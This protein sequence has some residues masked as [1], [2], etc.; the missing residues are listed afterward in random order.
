MK[1]SAVSVLIALMAL[2]A[3]V[4]GPA[5]SASS[6]EYEVTSTELQIPSRDTEIPATVVA[7]VAEADAT[8]PLVVLHHGHGGGRNENGGLARVAD[9]LAKAGIISIRF[10]FAGAGDSQEPFTE[11]SY[12]TMLADS[13]AALGYALANLPV[14]EERIGAFGYSEG[15]AVVAM[16]A[17]ESDTPYKAVALMGPVA[18]PMEVFADSWGSD[19]AFTAYYEEAQANGFAGVTTPWGQV[20]A[21]SLLWFDETL[22]ADPA[23]DIASFV[24]PVLIVWG[25]AEQ[26]IP[27]GEVEAY[28]ATT[29]GSATSTKVVTI[30]EADH[31]YGFYSDQ[32]EVDEL[33]HSSL[34]DFFT[35]ALAGEAGAG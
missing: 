12:T 10:D 15:S 26:V 34:V 24:G 6:E 27:Y 20:Q 32:P 16:Q 2:L 7:P 5:A 9:A 8:F 25:D 19:E 1:R 33:L 13:D 29:E 14:D 21:T 30:P 22:A 35:G 11:L 4:G 31:G 3:V 17:G 28:L 23:G 18:N